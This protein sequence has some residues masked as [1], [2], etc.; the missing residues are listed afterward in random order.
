MLV[1]PVT[2]DAGDHWF[3]TVF[4]LPYCTVT[5]SPFI[6]SNWWG[7]TLT[8]YTSCSSTNFHLLFLVSIDDS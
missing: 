6:I 4:R 5:T 1:C 2:G 3:E 8:M 7:N